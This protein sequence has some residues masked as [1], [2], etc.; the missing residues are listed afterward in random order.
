MQRYV[1]DPRSGELLLSGADIDGDGKLAP[2]GKGVLSYSQTRYEGI[3]DDN[4][5]HTVRPQ[6]GEPIDPLEST[7]SAIIGIL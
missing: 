2:G 1:Y 4:D 6:A 7:E 3:G 5:P